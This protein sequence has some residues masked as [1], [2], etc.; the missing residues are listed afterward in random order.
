[1][2]DGLGHG[3]DRVEVFCTLG[4]DQLETQPGGR[5]FQEMGGLFH[6][7]QDDD[8]HQVEEVVHRG[9]GEG[10]LE[11]GAA[12]HRGHGHQGVGDGGAHVGTHDD[13]DGHLHR[14]CSP[15]HHADHDRGRAGRALDQGGGQQPDHQTDDR[16]GGVGDQDL[17]GL[18]EHHLERLAEQGDGEQ[19][20]V[21][22]RQKNQNIEQNG[23][24]TG[25]LGNFGGHGSLEVGHGT[26]E[27]AIKNVIFNE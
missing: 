18:L 14:K 19:E 16:G 26:P 6:R 25:R 15:G 23:G 24:N 20:Y 17:A 8:G 4:P 13:G 3:L 11:L 12:V 5:F 10:P 1:M 2:N 21:K 9:P 27:M 22:Q 7:K